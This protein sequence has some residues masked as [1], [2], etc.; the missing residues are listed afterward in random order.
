MNFRSGEE[1]DR[2][3]AAADTFTDESFIAAELEFACE[4]ALFAG[5]PVFSEDPEF[6]ISGEVD[7]ASVKMPGEHVV[8]GEIFLVA[9]R[10]VGEL[11]SIVRV[12]YQ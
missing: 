3:E 11:V 8:E 1:A 7:L 6:E 5:D 9:V 12:M 10:T 2:Q 4:D